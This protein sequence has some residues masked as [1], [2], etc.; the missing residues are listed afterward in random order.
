MEKLKKPIIDIRP[1]QD[2]FIYRNSYYP[3]YFYKPTESEL[4][5]FHFQFPK[6]IRKFYKH[7]RDNPDFIDDH[8]SIIGCGLT[9]GE[10]SLLIH[11]I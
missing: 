5:H 1:S 4:R 6:L 8:T 10:L 9:I 11:K 7:I 3:I 2:K